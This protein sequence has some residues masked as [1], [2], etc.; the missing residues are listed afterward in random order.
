MVEQVAQ[1]KDIGEAIGRIPSGVYV[2]TAKSKDRKVGMLGS[3]VQQVGFEPPT[4][5]VAVHPD[6]ELYKT[7]EESGCF[8]INVLSNQN[9]N[10]MKNF[11][12]YSPDQFDG[13]ACK[14]NEWGI[15]LEDTVAV[16]NC[17]FVQKITASDHHL[18]IGEVV[19]GGI[20][21]RDEEPMVHLRK[22]GFN[23]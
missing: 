14:E 15:V 10:L 12:R 8:S 4:V 1:R 20:L 2:I 5:S 13:V 16:M 18:F 3:W 11:S 21:N 23:Y 22:S 17:R 7:I 6:R 9:M 19:D